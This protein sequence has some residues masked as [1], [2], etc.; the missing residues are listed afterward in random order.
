MRLGTVDCGSLLERHGTFAVPLPKGK[1][2]CVSVHRSVS[3]FPSIEIKGL[4][5]DPCEWAGGMAR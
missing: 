1:G 5:Q 3:D 2:L 4:L